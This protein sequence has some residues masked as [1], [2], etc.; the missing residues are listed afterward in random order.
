[1]TALTVEAL[2]QRISRVDDMIEPTFAKMIALDLLPF[3]ERHIAA[4]QQGAG[5]ADAWMHE[6]DP[7]RVISAKTKAGALADSGA[8]GSSVRSYSVPLHRLATPQPPTH[9]PDAGKMVSANPPEAGVTDEMVERLAKHLCREEWKD[10]CT[11]LEQL[12]DQLKHARRYHDEARAMLTA[13]LAP[14]P[15]DAT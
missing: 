15:K 8:S 3:I 6:D 4:G 7:T 5:D 13:A 12:T 11:N 14:Q 2:A 9:I 1:M 10:R